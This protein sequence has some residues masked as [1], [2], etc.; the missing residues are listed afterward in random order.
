MANAVKNTARNNL[1]DIIASVLRDRL[2]T[3][4]FANAAEMNDYGVKL[5]E[6]V[7]LIV[8]T[9]DSDPHGVMPRRAI[10]TSLIKANLPTATSRMAETGDGLYTSLKRS[11]TEDLAGAVDSILAVH[12]GVAHPTSQSPRS[13]IGTEVAAMLREKLSGPMFRTQDMIEA[14][15]ED[16]KAT[17]GLLVKVMASPMKEPAAQMARAVATIK[18]NLSGPFFEEMNL[19]NAHQQDIMDTAALILREFGPRVAAMAEI[20]STA[21]PAP[22]GSAPMLT[23]KMVSQIAKAFEG[24]G[25]ISYLQRVDLIAKT[26]GFEN[27]ASL[28][29]VLR[30][31]EDGKSASSPVNTTAKWIKPRVIMAYGETLSDLVVENETIPENFDGHFE[32]RTFETAA[33]V[34]AY[35]LGV[36]DGDGWM[37]WSPAAIEGA[38][39]H[40]TTGDFFVARAANPGLE[41]RDWHNEVLVRD[42]DDLE[43]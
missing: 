37:G 22:A 20:K 35:L 42:H 17:A 23:R 32:E 2:T 28:M 25:Q 8:E 19:R 24:A 40:D 11:E 29:A 10:I 7:D 34:E 39:D 1:R 9:L 21:A 43:P 12:P 26:I 13:S 38:G 16:I 4:V 6:T 41:Y 36:E 5:S 18:E 15:E 3:P 33:E 14:H 31:S 30:A 27:Q